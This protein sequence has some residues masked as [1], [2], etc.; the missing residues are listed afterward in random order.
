MMPSAIFYKLIENDVIIQGNASQ[1][2][3]EVGIR[4]ANI[5]KLRQVLAF[6]VESGNEAFSRI[7]IASLEIVHNFIQVTT[8]F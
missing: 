7:Q 1:V 2:R 8:G 4:F 6:L 3:T 5:G